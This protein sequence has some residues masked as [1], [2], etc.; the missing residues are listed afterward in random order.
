MT[1]LFALWH[2][3]RGYGGPA[4]WQLI[5]SYNNRPLLFR[6]EREAR[7]FAAEGLDTRHYEFAVAPADL[8]VPTMLQEA[9]A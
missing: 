1:R 4:T 5:T 9:V 7:A 2:R 8:T 3:S 6:S